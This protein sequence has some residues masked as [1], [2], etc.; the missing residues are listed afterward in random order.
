MEK[1]VFIYALCEPG[2]RTIRY[3]GKTGN[4]KNRLKSH[5]ANVKNKVDACHRADWI[6]SLLKRGL[7]PGIEIIDEVPESE[8]PSWE[9][10]YIQF[11]KELG[12]DLTNSTDGGECGS[13]TEAAREKNR[14]AHLGKPHSLKTREKMRGRV[15]W[16]RGIS[17]PREQV[18]RAAEK[19]RGRKASQL[20]LER[21]IAARTGKK[22]R[23]NTSGFVGVSWDRTKENY[24]SRLKDKYLGRFSKIEDAVFVYN[25]A[26]AN[27]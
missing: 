26:L 10:A 8:W 14:Q 27:I 3:I 20:E 25:L 23:D 13:Y 6:R 19:I 7:K 21:Q 17:P 16:N 22:R 24:M 18:E 9:A 1:T 15:A 4:L 12:A 11:F 5:L 2:T